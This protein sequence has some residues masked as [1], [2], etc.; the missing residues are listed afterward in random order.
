[1][2]SLAIERIAWSMLSQNNFRVPSIIFFTIIL[3][4]ILQQKLDKNIFWPYAYT[5][6]CIL[7][8]K[9]LAKMQEINEEATTYVDIIFHVSWTTHVTHEHGKHCKTCGQIEHNCHIHKEAHSWIF[10]SSVIS[11]IFAKIMS[12]HEFHFE[13]MSYYEKLF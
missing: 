8:L 1:M 7:F 6:T 12:Y 5:S 2:S 4:Q 9:S 10:L 3:L 11:W 13:T